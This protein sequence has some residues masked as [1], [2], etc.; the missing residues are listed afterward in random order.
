MSSRVRSVALL[1]D[2]GLGPH[3]DAGDAE[4]ALQPAAGGEGVGVALALVVVDALERD[5]RAAGHLGQRLLARHDG[6]AVD[7][8]RAAPALARRRAAVLGRRDV[9]L[10]AEGG[11]QVRVVGPDRPAGRSR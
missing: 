9:E 4:A 3:D 6:L 2:L 1:V 7:Q 11:E 10:L 5:D 8:H